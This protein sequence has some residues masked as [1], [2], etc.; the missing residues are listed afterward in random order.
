MKQQSPVHDTTGSMA[1]R[2][3]GHA[4]APN[5]R[6]RAQKLGNR[7]RDA[8]SLRG[9]SPLS[10][11]SAATER[12]RTEAGLCTGRIF[13]GGR[14]MRSRRNETMGCAHLAS[15]TVNRPWWAHDERPVSLVWRRSRWFRCLSL[16]QTAACVSSRFDA[17]LCYRVKM[18][19]TQFL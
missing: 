13:K 11:A 16:A 19:W 17:A 10:A 15:R 4:E 12:Q 18:S 5:R 1:E 14:G 6:P 3:D 9:S 8:T 7:K 2:T